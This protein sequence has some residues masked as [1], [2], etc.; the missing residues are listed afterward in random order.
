MS[1]NE[2]GIKLSP[3]FAPLPKGERKSSFSPLGRCVCMLRKVRMRGKEKNKKEK[4]IPLPWSST[5]TG[6]EVDFPLP[7][8]ERDKG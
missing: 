6:E 7:S 8:G 1:P 4:I 5:R 2:E 3:H